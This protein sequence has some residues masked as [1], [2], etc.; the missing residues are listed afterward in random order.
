MVAGDRDDHLSATV[1][2]F[3]GRPP[4]RACTRIILSA[5]QVNIFNLTNNAGTSVE[6]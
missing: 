5:G 2:S 6:L 3:I 1:L 4:A